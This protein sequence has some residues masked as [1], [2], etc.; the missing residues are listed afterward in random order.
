MSKYN[1][2]PV[3]NMCIEENKMLSHS[4]PLKIKTKPW[5]TNEIKI[6]KD[7]IFITVEQHC[8]SAI[9]QNK[10]HFIILTDLCQKTSKALLCTWF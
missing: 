2:R 8:G 6:H 10:K 5:K 7:G 9:N 1:F 3:H 4:V